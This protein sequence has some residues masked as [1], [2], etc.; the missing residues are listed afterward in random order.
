MLNMRF[1]YLS[2]LGQSP[3]NLCLLIYLHTVL[4][5]TVAAIGCPETETLGAAFRIAGIKGEGP[6]M[7]LITPW[8]FHIFLE[9]EKEIR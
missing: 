8:A 9:I 7:A 6:Q 1:F 3:L 5:G 4:L 2:F